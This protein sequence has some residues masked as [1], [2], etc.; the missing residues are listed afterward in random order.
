[1]PT[2]FTVTA[3]ELIASPPDLRFVHLLSVDGTKF[4][5]PLAI[6]AIQPVY[7]EP[8]EEAIGVDI[9]VWAEKGWMMGISV[10]V[11][12]QGGFKPWITFLEVR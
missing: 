5:P 11:Q 1:M 9:T 7:P 2:K 10:A 4:D 12:G 3:R 6:E 8:G